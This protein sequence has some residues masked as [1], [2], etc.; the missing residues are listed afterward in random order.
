MQSSRK[1]LPW[2]FAPRLTL[3]QWLRFFAA[4][5]VAYLL[6]N[7]NNPLAQVLFLTKQAYLHTTPWL[8]A[9]K[10]IGGGAIYAAI[11]FA[12]LWWAGGRGAFRQLFPRIRWRDFGIYCGY[13]LLYPVFGILG[14]VATIFVAT[15]PSA[16]IKESLASWQQYSWPAYRLMSW[17]GVFT[18]TA[19]V[20]VTLMIFL[21]IIQMLDGRMQHHP[22]W[23]NLCVYLI[24]GVLAGAFATT[25]SSPDLWSNVVVT[26]F[27]QLPLLWSYRRSRNLG[28]PAL[29]VWGGHRLL[30]GLMLM[31]NIL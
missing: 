16:N 15:G 14:H 10:V 19:N 22:H 3:N 27:T 28:V 4:A 21:A 9:L 5:W 18:T 1:S 7:T 6:F 30:T 12:G 29:I 23:R 25:L 31:L 13:G 26:I 8:A 24:T 2:P 11:I 17:Q 20:L